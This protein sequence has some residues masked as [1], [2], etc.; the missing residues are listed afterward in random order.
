MDAPTTGGQPPDTAACIRYALGSGMNK[1]TRSA[2]IFLVASMFGAGGTFGVFATAF[3]DAGA[4]RTPDG[5]DAQP[6]PSSCSLRLSGTIAETSRCVVEQEYEQP[7]DSGPVRVVISQAIA[8]R[9]DRGIEVVFHV[10][11]KPSVGLQPSARYVAAARA[12]DGSSRW[13]ALL[14]GG[15]A[16][17]L[18][19]FQLTL[20]TVR[21]VPA[22]GS[23]AY[24]IHGVIDAQLLPTVE[25]A[26]TGVVDLHVAF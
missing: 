23:Q 26:A 12:V 10:D 3:A 15:S 1:T 5:G 11:G 9:V 24:E 2:S 17:S 6:P 18:G 21:P 16:G 14:Y 13:E 19:S 20:T 4:A 22:R 7:R 8:T 25:S